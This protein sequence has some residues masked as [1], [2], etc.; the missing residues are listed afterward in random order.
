MIF[1]LILVL[2][3]SNQ[4]MLFNE[5]FFIILAFFSLCYIVKTNLGS[6]VENELLD[7]KNKV[8]SSYLEYLNKKSKYLNS[9]VK[10]IEQ[11][12]EYLYNYV[13]IQEV[14]FTKFSEFFELSKTQ[15]LLELNKQIES[16]FI[17]YFANLI[18][19]KRKF[20]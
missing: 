8:L 1:L 12:V 2:I 10:T 6:V 14:Y 3:F 9:S 17:Y 11:K 16:S 15:S 5:E 7:R 4:Y 18:A 19:K 13:N 20:L